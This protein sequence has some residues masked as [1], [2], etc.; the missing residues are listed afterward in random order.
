MA[1]ELHWAVKVVRD[2]TLEIVVFNGITLGIS[3]GAFLVFRGDALSYFGLI[4]LLF[5][6]ALML[7]GGALD[8]TTT[9]S[10]RQMTRQLR[11]LFRARVPE[12]EEEFT[13]TQRR[14]VGTTAATYA[15]TGVL[16]FLEAGSLTLV[17]V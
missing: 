1:I 16:L 2:S 9:G 10:A 14:K 17:F 6:V 4:L 8:L 15:V 12:L 13:P 7:L 3:L 11:M 5:S